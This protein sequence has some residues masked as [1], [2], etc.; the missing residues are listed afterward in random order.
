MSR[1]T[2]EAIARAAIE[3]ADADGLDAVSMRRVALHLEVGT[4]SLYHY[5]ATKQDLFSV[6]ADAIMAENLIPE[7]EVPD[8]WREGLA[9]IAHRAYRLFTSHDWVLAS[10][11][12]SD[13]GD[14]GPSLVKH[15]EQTLAI[16]AELDFLT[17]PQRLQI[18][19]LV[20]EYTI[21]YVTRNT[22]V[23]PIG[24]EED[25][26]QAY[27]AEQARSGAYPHLAAAF[28]AGVHAPAPDGFAFGLDRLLDGI[29]VYVEAQRTRLKRS[30]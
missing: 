29:E 22:A 4:M 16:V 23:A 14:P 27:V 25:R 12:R 24:D 26:W 1:L 20:D 5:V 30:V 9:E 15:I 17:I 3:I 11:H 18:T 6:M 7:D 21:G 28:E 8:G 10:W 2:R 19:G 13:R